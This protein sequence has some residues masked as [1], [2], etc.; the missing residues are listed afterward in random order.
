M[1]DGNTLL[2]VLKIV[3]PAA[4]AIVVLVLLMRPILKLLVGQFVETL[5][6]INETQK[7][8]QQRL[9]QM[10]TREE[11]ATGLAD[12]RGTRRDDEM[13]GAMREQTSKLDEQT[14]ALTELRVV[15]ETRL[16]RR[17]G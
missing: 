6:G 10:P 16:D 1:D 2:E 5:K 17:V 13:L 9:S 14:K 12:C 3:G 8:I 15:L 4:A 11:L 7:G